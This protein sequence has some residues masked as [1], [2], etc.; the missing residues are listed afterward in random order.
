MRKIL[1]AG[2][3]V[4]W[5]I[6]QM[7]TLY[8]V[9]LEALQVVSLHLGFALCMTFLYIP[10]KIQSLDD[11]IKLLVDV[12]FSLL[13]LVVSFYFI[14]DYDRIRNHMMF[15]SGFTLSDLLAGGAT[16]LLTI[17]A[18]RRVLGWPL[19]IL[20]L[21]SLGYLLI[22][23]YISG[24]F[25]SRPISVAQ[26]IEFNYFT[27]NGLFGIALQTSA[28]YVYVFVLFAS[29]LDKSGLGSKFMDM[30][31]SFAGKWRGGPA[32]VGVLSSGFFGMITGSA[33]SNVAFTGAFTI[34]TMKKV[35]F[36]PAFAGAVE[37]VASSAGMITPPLLG[38]AVFLIAQ[39]TQTEIA[40][41]VVASIVPAVLYF[42]ALFIQVDLESA[43][44][45]IQ[46]IDE[47]LLPKFRH[48]LKEGWH[49][50]VPIGLI[51]VMLLFGYSPQLSAALSIILVVF[52]SYVKK[53]S[54]LDLKKLIDACIETGKMMTVIATATATAGIIIASITYAGLEFKLSS[55]LIA[56]AG[57]NLLLLTVFTAALSILLGMGLPVF[58][59]YI[60]VALMTAPIMLD[61]G[62][63]VIAAHL[64]VFYYAMMSLYTPPVA[65]TAFVAAGLAGA[66][67]FDVG[68]RSM[69]LGI[70][71]LVIPFLFLYHPSLLTLTIS[72][73]I[74][75][76]I[77]I[78]IGIY[79]LA[80]VLSGY[81]KQKLLVWEAVSLC[82]LV[83]LLF[84]PHL[85]A[86]WMSLALFC[87]F[88]KYHCGK[89]MKLRHKTPDV[90]VAGQPE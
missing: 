83:I 24:V 35:G 15:I 82:C 40:T 88:Y 47:T 9:N 85:L 11:R 43:K 23:P 57:D 3:A 6:T 66:D 90:T 45:N 1:M 50:L 29:L 52:L 49:L 53:E 38:T 42:L 16:I 75:T 84:W 72:Q 39:F 25:H 21:I 34:P 51:V 33:S 59:A 76:L 56:A 31:I 14:S 46:P 36:Q 69:K 26:I 37:S 68:W 4:I 18:T 73:L 41:I 28:T 79:G 44:N 71:G 74:P 20:T 10:L 87:F 7:I 8:F 48:S 64:F 55:F 61:A 22:G 19:T 78:V 27:T 12:A 17:E 63:E 80:A 77:P 2:V 81:M 30:I 58:P 5:A 54:R 70:G 67:P 86:Q 13:T 62:V 32:K 65:P 60:I 89:A